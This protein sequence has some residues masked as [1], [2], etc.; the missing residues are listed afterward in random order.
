MYTFNAL[1]IN[2]LSLDP[3]ISIKIDFL[4]PVLVN[5]GQTYQVSAFSAQIKYSNI[6][7]FFLE[8]FFSL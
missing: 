5:V 1:I 8:L 3:F 6:D 7:M 4:N 2:L